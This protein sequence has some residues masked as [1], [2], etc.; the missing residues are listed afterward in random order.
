MPNQNKVAL[1]TGGSRGIGF[2][3]ALR[4]A[5]EGFTLVISGKR[6]REQI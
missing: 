6:T 1:V 3:V 5:E 4:L 2:G